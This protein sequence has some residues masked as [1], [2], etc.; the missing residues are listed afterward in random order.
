VAGAATE[1]LAIDT[2]R[3]YHRSERPADAGQTAAGEA[4]RATDRWPDDGRTRRRP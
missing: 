1:P 2:P 3:G 4:S